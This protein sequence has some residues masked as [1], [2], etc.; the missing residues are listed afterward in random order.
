MALRAT[1]GDECQRVTF[2]RAV[3]QT[4]SRG[5][6]TTRRTAPFSRG[7]VTRSR[8]QCRKRSGDRGIGAGWQAGSQAE[9][10]PHKI[11]AREESRLHKRAGPTGQRDLRESARELRYAE[12][13]VNMRRAPR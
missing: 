12:R 8:C 4:S 7:S 11:P 10:L 3:A 9:S 13:F 6:E 5:Q 2:E 1:H